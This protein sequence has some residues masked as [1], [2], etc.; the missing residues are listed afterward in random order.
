MKCFTLDLLFCVLCSL[1]PSKN[2]CKK[3]FGE[4]LECEE[5]KGGMGED[6]ASATPPTC[7]RALSWFSVA[8]CA[9]WS[10]FLDG[11]GCSTAMCPLRQAQDLV[12]E[13]G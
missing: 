12:R 7:A 6:L 13:G 1:F 11:L 5:E 8:F 4:A 10:R 2:K 9:S 3:D